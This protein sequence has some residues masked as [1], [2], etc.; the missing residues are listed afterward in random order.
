MVDREHE[1]LKSKWSSPGNRVEILIGHLSFAVRL[2]RVHWSHFE[3]ILDDPCPLLYLATSQA[4]VRL[5]VCDVKFF[6]H[7]GRRTVYS[8]REVSTHKKHHSEDVPFRFKS[9][10]TE[11]PDDGLRFIQAVVWLRQQI[12]YRWWIHWQLPTNFAVIT[13]LRDSQSLPVDT[14]QQINSCTLP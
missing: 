12:D 5:S 14:A 13:R 7:H 8:T 6:C 9:L 1:S 10:S 3:W 4:L 2:H 11:T